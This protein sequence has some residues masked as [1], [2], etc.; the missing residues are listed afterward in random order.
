MNN[1]NKALLNDNDLFN[2]YFERMNLN[3]D[4]KKI[5]EI[6]GND[7]SIDEFK[8]MNNLTNLRNENHK[9][10]YDI[11]INKIQNLPIEFKEIV[12]DILK[13]YGFVDSKKLLI[14]SYE[15]SINN[16]KIID[17]IYRR[18]N[19][20]DQ[21]VKTTLKELN[22][23]NKDKQSRFSLTYFE[24]LNI[25]DKLRKELI[26]KYN[27]LV[28]YNSII[29]TD[30]YSELKRQLKCKEYIDNILKSLNLYE[31]NKLRISTKEKLIKLNKKI[32]Q[33][34]KKHEGVISYLEDLMPKGSKHKEEFQDFKNFYN[35]IIAYDDTDYEVAKQTYEILCDDTKFNILINSFEER[36]INEID[37]RNKEEKFI[38][39]KVGIKNVKTSL[40]YIATNYMNDLEYDDKKIIEDIFN[41][42]S[43]LDYD[44][45]N[46]YNK[47]N[48]IVKKIWKNKITDVYS[49]NPNQDFA[50]ICA[51]NQ[52][53]DEKYQT[54]LIT[55]KELERVDDYSDY[56]IGFICSYNENILY[57]TENE[58]I[59]S[60]NYD[61]MSNLKTPIQL[62]QE[63][64]NFKVCNR[65]ALNGYI[66][67][68]QAIYYINDKSVDT[69]MKAIEL[70]NMY[71][72][73]L[74]ELKKST[75]K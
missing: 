15:E 57:I 61:D 74:I 63:F 47:L 17:N 24:T 40:N 22:L 66:T 38:L 21:M 53:I 35:K 16:K 28:L 13:F 11:D 48:V 67:K 41:E 10:Y 36:F 70:A 30:S 72:L 32:N 54:I 3:E 1:E 42:L 39:E 7:D 34:I 29:E 25:D 4:I 27:D 75:S 33:E 60:V 44:L 14:D 46:I 73:P 23:Y 71:K 58:D 69:Y 9:R 68:I 2:D 49:Y 56:Q 12:D 65:I 45:N 51:N 20:L 50:F 52:F 18:F 43:S 6:I 19:R 26:E 62:E 59:M 31:D 64:I 55:K 5:Y 37:Q 8:K